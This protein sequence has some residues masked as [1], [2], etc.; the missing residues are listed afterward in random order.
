MS[1]GV[2]GASSRIG[3]LGSASCWNTE[4]V[5]IRMKRRQ[6]CRRAASSRLAV[7]PTL[8]WIAVSGW[9]RA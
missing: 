2:G 3:R 1:T 5:L 4:P 9:G 7:A 8:L 6:P